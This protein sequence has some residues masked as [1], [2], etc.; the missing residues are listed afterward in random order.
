MHVIREQGGLSKRDIG[1]IDDDLVSWTIG[2]GWHQRGIPTSVP[3]GIGWRLVARIL[4]ES[5]R[6]RSSFVRT[7]R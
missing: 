5:D 7:S 3:K 4:I 1:D 6:F 2:A